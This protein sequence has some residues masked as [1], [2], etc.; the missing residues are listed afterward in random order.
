MLELNKSFMRPENFI[1]VGIP[2]LEDKQIW[3]SIPVCIMYLITVFGNIVMLYVILSEESL[4]KP[5]YLF[6]SMLS[7]IDLVASST[8]TPK[9]LWI[10]WFNSSKII[11]DACLTQMFFI[12]ALSMMESTVLLAMA[13]D[14]Y[15]AICHPLRYNSILTNKRIVTIGVL[16]ILRGSFLMT[17]CV[18]LIKRLSYCRT[19]VIYHTYCEHMAVVKI[20]CSD[21]TI[22]QVYGLI[23][24]LLVIA[25]DSVCVT[26]SYTVI[27]RAVMR[28]SSNEARHKAASTCG[29]HICVILISYVP[30]LFSFFSHRFGHN[31]SPSVHITFANLYIL[32][33]PMCNPIIYGVKTKEIQEKIIVIFYFKQEKSIR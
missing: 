19:N 8:T 4:H 12:H 5:M 7:I 24:A 32:I 31:I 22:N 1:L 3:I 2:G 6:L 21:T 25:V 11:F 30:A 23:A 10:F 18:L 29:S 27:V 16:A 33:P 14:R 13:F 17:P 15:V 26:L 20:A 9:I 28:L